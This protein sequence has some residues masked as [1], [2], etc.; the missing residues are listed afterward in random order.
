M[1]GSFLHESKYLCCAIS[2]LCSTDPPTL[3]CVWICGAQEAQKATSLFDDLGDDRFFLLYLSL[4]F[5]PPSFAPSFCGI[6]LLS[7]P[8]PLLSVCILVLSF[9]ERSL[10]SIP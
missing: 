8:F 4:S 7:I 6:T 2:L 5:P 1:I 3:V 9:V 10:V